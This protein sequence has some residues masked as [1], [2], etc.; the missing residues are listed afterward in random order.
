M[1]LVL[2]NLG[3]FGIMI[4]GCKNHHAVDITTLME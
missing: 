4:S 2:T 1:L 3:D